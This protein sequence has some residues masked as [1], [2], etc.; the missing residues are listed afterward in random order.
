[1]REFAPFL[2]YNAFGDSAIEFTV[3]LRVR[4][5]PDRHLVTHEFVKRL[6]RRFAEEGIEIPFPQLVVHRPEPRG[7]SARREPRG[8]PGS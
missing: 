4:T 3:I 1:V 6:H 5:N 8:V 7:D 2:R